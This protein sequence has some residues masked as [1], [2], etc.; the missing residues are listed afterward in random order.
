VQTLGQRPKLEIALL[1]ILQVRIL[2]NMMRLACRG[3]VLFFNLIPKG[4]GGDTFAAYI[5]CNVT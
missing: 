5:V 2:Y 4:N 3:P 1:L